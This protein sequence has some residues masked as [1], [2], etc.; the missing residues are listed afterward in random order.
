M[1]EFVNLETYK[2]NGDFV[3]YQGELFYVG[4]NIESLLEQGF[5][6]EE[7]ELEITAHINS[8]RNAGCNKLESRPYSTGITTEEF[9]AKEFEMDATRV[10]KKDG[11]LPDSNYFILRRLKNIPSNFPESKPRHVM[12]DNKTKAYYCIS[13]TCTDCNVEPVKAP[14]EY[15]IVSADISAQ[16]P[17]CSTLVTRET[18]W[19]SVFTLKNF[20]YNAKLLQML[21]LIMEEYLTIPKTDTDYILFIHN[22]YSEDKTDLIK[23]NLLVH[24]SKIDTSKESDLIEH[25]K[26]ILS[27]FEEYKKSS[28]E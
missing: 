9:T 10:L 5:E 4:D 11:Y 19:A 6:F 26:V 28:K 16:E 13:N 7:S 20:R 21:D 27:K 23:L 1:S 3:E 15:H 17:M 18:Q 25:I 12:W 8:R 2:E 14:A 22:T 24:Q